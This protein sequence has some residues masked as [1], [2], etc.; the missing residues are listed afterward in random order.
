M[1]LLVRTGCALVL[2]YF[3]FILCLTAYG[4]GSAGTLLQTGAL[5]GIGVGLIVAAHR[6]AV[7]LSLPT[8][9]FDIEGEPIC[10]AC[11][12]PVDP[13]E[14]YCPNCGET[15]GMYT[16]YIPYVNIWFQYQFFG[17][18]WQQAWGPDGGSLPRRLMLLFF[19]GLFAGPMILIGLPFQVMKLFRGE[20]LST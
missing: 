6:A 3:G 4:I 17:R 9:E 20:G 8:S 10:T 14:Y 18:V 5:V 16:P 1:P 11:C 2:A 7:D 13:H 12:V 15:S 19:I